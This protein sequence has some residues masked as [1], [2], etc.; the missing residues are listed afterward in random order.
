MIAISNLQTLSQLSRDYCKKSLSNRRIKQK[1]RTVYE[2]MLITTSNKLYNLWHKLIHSNRIFYRSSLLAVYPYSDLWIFCLRFFTTIAPNATT[3]T[4]A[5]TPTA[6]PAFL[7]ELIPPPDDFPSS[8]IPVWLIA[9]LSAASSGD[10]AGDDEGE[11]EG[12]EEGELSGEGAGGESEW[13]DGVGVGVGAGGDVAGEGVGIGV[14]EGEFSDEFVAGVGAGESAE[15]AM[16]TK[17]ER[18]RKTR[19][20]LA[21]AIDKIEFEILNGW[22]W[23]WVEKT[24]TNEWEWSWIWK[25]G[26]DKREMKGGGG[27][28]R[29]KNSIWG[30]NGWLWWMWGDADVWH[31]DCFVWNLGKVN[32]VEESWKFREVWESEREVG[33]VTH[34]CV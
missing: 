32:V 4:A 14:G 8:P 16:L 24:V 1:S 27:L 15:E 18:R 5:I 6:I 28:Y 3:P 26:G 19:E 31:V 33:N 11:G 25:N 22:I 30:W 20:N 17:K 13:G 2:W 21:I 34:L 23:N 7:P 29:V 9:L 12:E 10:G